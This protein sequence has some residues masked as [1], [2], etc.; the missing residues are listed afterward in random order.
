MVP[1]FLFLF[2]FLFHALVFSFENAKLKYADP[3][4]WVSQPSKLTGINGVYFSIAKEGGSSAILISTTSQRPNKMNPNDF[5]RQSL[6][7][8]QKNH[9]RFALFSLKNFSELKIPHVVKQFTYVKNGKKIKG[10]VLLA[11]SEADN[12]VFHFTVNEDLYSLYESEVLAVM[13]SLKI[14]K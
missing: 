13:K 2:I 12:H 14:K 5:L 11:Q 3:Q 8:D 4:G 9:E 7:A 1:K 6:A 10:L